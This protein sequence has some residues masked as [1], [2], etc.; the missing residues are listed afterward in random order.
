MND[1][2]IHVMLYDIVAVLLAIHRCVHTDQTGIIGAQKA[3]I[4]RLVK[5]ICS[6][7]PYVLI[8]LLEAIM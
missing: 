6:L 4:T 3:G 8:L 1:A 7:V 2:T 5:T